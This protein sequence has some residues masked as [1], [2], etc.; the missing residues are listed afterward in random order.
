MDRRPPL[1]PPCSSTW[2]EFRSDMSVISF[3]ARTEDARG[4]RH[5]STASTLAACTTLALTVACAQPPV[6]WMGEPKFLDARLSETSGITIRG[7]PGQEGVTVQP[8][9]TPGGGLPQLG[10]GA[11]LASVRWGRDGPAN[12]AVAWWV[13]RPDSSV[14]LR[15]SVSRDDGSHWDS[16][17]T[18]DA[19]DRGVRGCT[20]PA[21]A[22][23]LD[24]KSGYTHLAYFNEPETGA[25]IFYE[26]LM[27]IP[28][29][30]ASGPARGQAMFHAPVAIVYGETPRES[31]VT[32]HGDTVVVAYED[33]NGPN[34]AIEVKASTT[35]GHSFMPSVAASGS[36]VAAHRPL[37]T[38]RDWTVAVAWLES[39]VRADGSETSG[40]AVSDRT[41]VRVGLLR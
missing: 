40:S 33:P 8:V 10:A 23:A 30:T 20:R 34:A 7:A 3:V 32:A 41:V 17:A 1:H 5:S 38:V 28:I 26:H 18:A 36:G 9:P 22:V 6:R 39:P 14:T 27:E 31:A 16:S 13:V 19:R 25:G 12:V 35:A 24:V 4:R 21:P 2:L 15:L 29:E 37:V 11:C